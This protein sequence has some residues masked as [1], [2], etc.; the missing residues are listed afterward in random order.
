M[1]PPRIKLGPSILSA[2]FA[3]MGR[4]IGEVNASGAD[5]VHCD[6]MDGLF[7]PN[8]SFGFKMVADIR[9]HSKLPLDVHLMIVEPHRYVERFIDAGADIV[10]IHLESETCYIGTLE[11]IRKLG[12]RAGAVIKPNTDVSA[13]EPV[14]ELVDLILLM[15]VEPG[16]GGQSFI[17]HVLGKI[18]QVREMIAKSGRVIELEVDGGI[19]AANAAEVT[20]AGA[21]VLVAGN[22][23]FNAPDK[24]AFCRAL[25]GG[26]GY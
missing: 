13:L 3:Q 7:V 21:D 24:A 25:R 11:K 4:A 16:F 9:K 8:L 18:S 20:G 6:V 1:V 12:A 14:M 15:S 23:F 2:D 26:A 10:T 5:Y 17:P 19:G 22:A